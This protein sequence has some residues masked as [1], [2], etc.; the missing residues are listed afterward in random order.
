ML[1]AARS[2]AQLLKSLL[3]MCLIPSTLKG[4]CGAVIPVCRGREVSSSRL[5]TPAKKV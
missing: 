2:V 5:P 4:K 1:E 3:S